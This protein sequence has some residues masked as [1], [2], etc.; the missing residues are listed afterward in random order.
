MMRKIGIKSPAHY[1]KK[2]AQL[3][4]RFKSALGGGQVG[5]KPGHPFRGNQYS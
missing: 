2:L 4:T 3:A 1:Y 5:D